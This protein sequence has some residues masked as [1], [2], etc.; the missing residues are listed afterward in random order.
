MAQIRAALLN[1][2]ALTVLVT[3]VISQRPCNLYCDENDASTLGL[4]HGG[5][6]GS[7]GS[8]GKRGGKG[9]RGAKGDKGDVGECQCNIGSSLEDK[10]QILEDDKDRTDRIL[11][12]CRA[13][14]DETSKRSNGVY[15]VQ[16][17]NGIRYP[18]YC[19]MAVGGGGWTLVASIHENN[20][21]STGRCSVG[22]RWS[23]ETGN[24]VGSHVGAENWM[25]LN[26][27]GDVGSATS[28]DYKN[29]AYFDLQARDVM[30]WQVPND[31]PLVNYS[32]AAYVQYH[33]SNGFLSRFGGNLYH[34]YND[35][36]P[37]KSGTIRRPNDNGPAISV[38]FDKGDGEEVLRHFGPNI[39]AEIEPGYLQFRVIN[40]EGSVFALCPG[41]RT[42]PNRGNNE[43]HCIGSTA[44]HRD[45]T[46]CGDFSSFAHQGYGTGTRWDADMVLLKTTYLVFYR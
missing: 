29:H 36:F 34:L 14:R 1:F 27:F 13:I 26:T 17:T 35:H 38:V 10:L 39:Q 30:I 15:Y 41:T 23:S 16:D 7:T 6:K 25:N 11:S 24:E 42:K 19:D 33:T 20:I 4:G 37:I 28:D 22:D 5:V 44:D 32:S 46:Y 8:P 12:S 9:D 3:F 40:Y 31:T 45:V 18:V 2:L 21:R 43:H